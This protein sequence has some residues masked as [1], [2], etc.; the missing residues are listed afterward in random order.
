MSNF[1]IAIIYVLGA[2]LIPVLP[3]RLR[4]ST[5]LVLSVVAF[6]FLLQLESGASLT[7]SFLN[8]DL[9]LCRVDRLSL[10]F[11]YVFVI[12]GFLGGIYGF[13]V[14]DTLQQVVALLYVGSSLG[15]VFA[16]DLF[17]LLVFWEIM[18]ISSLFLIWAR[19]TPEARQAGF[20]YLLVHAFGGSILMAGILWHIG[21]TGSILFNH[22]EGGIAS[23][24]ILFAFALNAAVPPLNGWLPDSYPEGTVTGSVFLSAFT[25]KVA[26]YALARG[27]AGLEL[28]MWAGAVMA[29]YG[30]VFAFLAND[31]RRLLSYHI[32]SQVG[33]MVCGVGI[34]T[35]VAVNGATAHAFAHI[36]YKGLLFMGMGTVL[37]AT[38]RNKM[39][40]LGGLVRSMWLPL[41]FFM[42]GAFSISGVP[43]FSGFVSKSI[44]IH[45]AE[46]EHLGT[47][48]LLLNLASIGTFLSIGLKLPYFTWFS[49]DRNLK[50]KPVPL[51]M[52][53][54]MGLTSVICIAIGVYPALLYNLLPYPVHYQPYTTGHLLET[55]QLLIF[56]GLAFWLVIRKLHAEE[57]ITLDTDWFYRRPSRLA[58]N[59]FSVSICR[60]FGAVE[61][62]SLRLVRFTVKLGANPPGYLVETTRSARYFFFRTKKPVPEPLTFSPDRYRITLGVMVLVVLLCLI[63]LLAWD[64]FI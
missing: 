18:A 29:V 30:V 46:L 55:M 22:F 39:T 26:V 36:L 24:L 9:V 27:F 17:T 34:G 37:Y 12:M 63:V 28:L 4:S 25:T 61:N 54:G 1:P 52:Y 35:E 62:L 45:A 56:T 59:V 2:V 40:E 15:V 50:P 60:L 14:K 33:Y 49:T 32:I 47:V 10:A 23:Y 21:E 3:R 53:I 48:V 7:A 20:R 64:I 43:L 41:I 13:H 58:Y 44:V 5:C 51:G 8:Y 11:G 16:G 6:V 57:N 38:G 19:R 31:G 42:V